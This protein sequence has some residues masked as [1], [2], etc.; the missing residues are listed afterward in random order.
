MRN[1]LPLMPLDF[2]QQMLEMQS[3]AETMKK[4]ENQALRKMFGSRIKQSFLIEMKERVSRNPDY[5]ILAPKI[6]D[7]FNF[8]TEK[9]VVGTDNPSFDICKHITMIHYVNTVLLND[10]ER[11]SLQ[12]DEKYKKKLE[13]QVLLQIKLRFFGEVDFTKDSLD[14]FLPLIYITN[15][16]GNY[17]IYSL[18]NIIKSKSKVNQK[19]YIFKMQILWRIANKIRACCKLIDVRLIE[20]AYNPLRS[21]I[22]LVM[23]FLVIG[24]DENRSNEYMKF[25]EYQNQYQNTMKIP[26]ELQDKYNNRFPKDTKVSIIDYMNFGWLDVIFEFGYIEE[27]EKKYKIHDVALLLDMVYKINNKLGSKL[28]Q[29]YR[30]CNTLSHGVIKGVNIFTSRVTICKEILFVLDLIKQIL[31]DL[32]D[33]DFVYNDIDFFEYAMKASKEIDKIFK[34]LET[35]PKLNEK[36]NEGNYLSII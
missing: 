31:R 36:L 15:V 34:E 13:D 9:M 23:I 20:E 19:N 24:L 4:E 27:K 33:L 21:M 28:Y 32:F 17:L 25:V 5:V 11:G 8:S 35:N 1:N 22:D 30:D 12:S 2:Q 18:N 3:F 16:I 26:Q 7:L 10:G 14:S 29:Y 6:Y